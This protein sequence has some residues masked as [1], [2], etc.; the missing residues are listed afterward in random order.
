MLFRSWQRLL[1]MRSWYDS[2]FQRAASTG[3]LIRFPFARQDANKDELK[4]KKMRRRRICAL[5]LCLLCIAAAILLPLFLVPHGVS[6][7][8]QALDNFES[9]FQGPAT[10]LL[11]FVAK[12]HRCEQESRANRWVLFRC[13]KL[14]KSLQTS[15]LPL[16][17]QQLYSPFTAKVGTAGFAIP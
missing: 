7:S 14:T 1:L 12:V 4:K 11:V 15:L 13:P 5:F 8:Q 10:A 2:E 9:I 6:T 17:S 16:L 3:L